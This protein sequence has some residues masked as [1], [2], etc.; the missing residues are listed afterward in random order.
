MKRLSLLLLFIL[1]IPSVSA[2]QIPGLVTDIMRSLFLNVPSDYMLKFM[3]WL[4]TFSILY[5]AAQ[6]I[7]LPKG[8]GT[9]I[10]IVIAFGSAVFLPVNFI[11]TIFNTYS[12]IFAIVL[13]VVPI[14]AILYVVHNIKQKTSGHPGMSHALTALAYFIAAYVLGMTG[15]MLLDIES[16][17]PGFGAWFPISGIMSVATFV[18]VILGF[19]N[20]IKIFTNAGSGATGNADPALDRLRSQENAALEQEKDHEKKLLDKEKKEKDLAKDLEKD[21]TNLKNSLRLYVNQ[22]T[23]KNLTKVEKYVSSLA[24]NDHFIERLDMQSQ[25]EERTLERLR[26]A[27]DRAIK[28]EEKIKHRILAR[29]SEI[30]RKIINE[31]QMFVQNGRS[32]E[33]KKKLLYEMAR[34]AQEGKQLTKDLEK[35]EKEE[36]NTEKDE[37]KDTKKAIST[38]ARATSSH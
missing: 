27:E 29:E 18:F 9:T 32:L 2:I 31:M 1:G 34:L 12:V 19:W 20:I 14:A 24:E 8:T 17:L 22:P 28:E 25:E 16:Q 26:G 10:A 30:R 3:F 21:F 36:V 13:T 11:R 38:N 7:K 4:L 5:F 6:A 33:Q 15:T 35:V 37:L 23:D